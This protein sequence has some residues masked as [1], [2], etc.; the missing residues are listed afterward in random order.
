[1]RDDDEIEDEVEQLELILVLEGEVFKP[2]ILV[3]FACPSVEEV[4]VG[5]LQ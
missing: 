4:D 3:Q 2:E 1:M 5:G